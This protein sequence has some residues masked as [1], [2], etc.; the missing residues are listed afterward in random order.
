MQDLATALGRPNPNEFQIAAHTLLGAI[1]VLHEACSHSF[2]TKVFTTATESQS[3]P[4]YRSYNY[5][6]PRNRDIAWQDGETPCGESGFW[7]E[8]AGIGGL[9]G[10]VVK[11]SQVHTL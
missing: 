9:F 4:A 2:R 6:I 7:L 10:C 5:R 11:Q 3:P 1:T 8:D